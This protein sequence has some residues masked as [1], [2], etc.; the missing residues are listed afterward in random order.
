[1]V[2]VCSCLDF[3]NDPPAFQA[4]KHLYDMSFS[5]DPNL[6]KLVV[7]AG[8]SLFHLSDE[9]ANCQTGGLMSLFSAFMNP[10]SS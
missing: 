9:R 10:Q 3:R 8:K 5:R 4:I 2:Y 7:A 6:R 1:M